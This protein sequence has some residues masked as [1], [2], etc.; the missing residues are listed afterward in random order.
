MK[1]I[2]G[3]TVR[4]VRLCKWWSA[5]ME[6]P[7]TVFTGKVAETSGKDISLD[8]RWCPR[9]SNHLGNMKV[10]TKLYPIDTARLMHL[11]GPGPGDLNIRG[12]WS[13]ST[14]YIIHTPGKYINKNKMRWRRGENDCKDPKWQEA[15]AK[16]VFETKYVQD[17][18]ERKQGEN[19][20]KTVKWC[21]I[22]QKKLHISSVGSR[23][24]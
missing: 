15:N 8:W 22:I 13:Y 6:T 14:L 20:T 23:G 18:R 7:A 24:L 4:R 2:R 5:V 1:S 17:C 19:E 9:L 21:K 10:C 12:L 3:E 16:N 11:L